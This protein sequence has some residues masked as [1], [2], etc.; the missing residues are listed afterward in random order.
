[1]RRLPVILLTLVATT[2]GCSSVRDRLPDVRELYR[3]ASL[4][5]ARNPVV[6]IHGIL[7][8]RLE[9]RATRRT[10]WGAFTGDYADPETP[11]GACLVALPLEIP[12]SASACDPAHQRVIATEP[13]G[14]IRLGILFGVVNVDVY[15]QILRTLGVG[16]YRDRVLVDPETPQYTDDHFTCSTFFYDWRRD[17]VENAI[18]FGAAR[19]AAAVALIRPSRRRARHGGQQT[20]AVPRPARRAIGRR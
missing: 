15:A 12:A 16:G 8:A 2:T 11:D 7:G 20:A 14:R 9:E 10:V 17:N 1:M 13:L 3:D 6:V 5:E 4:R 18:R 19:D